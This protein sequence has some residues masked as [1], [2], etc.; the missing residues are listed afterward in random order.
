PREPPT[1]HL[2]LCRFAT[3]F[4]LKGSRG[5]RTQIDFGKDAR[6]VSSNKFSNCVEPIDWPSF[7]DKL[8]A[9]VTPPCVK[10]L[11]PRP[12]VCH[13]PKPAAMFEPRRHRFCGGKSRPFCR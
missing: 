13:W 2:K 11:S 6:C 5:N 12:F 1:F 8:W 4:I 3:R 9:V 7:V 10:P